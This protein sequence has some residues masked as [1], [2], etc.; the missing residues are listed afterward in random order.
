M[1]KPRAA[2]SVQMRN[3]ISPALKADRFALRSS[4]DF[5]P[6]NTAQEYAEVCKL[7]DLSYPHL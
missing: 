3:L 7:A 1:S 6:P 5:V 4:M 2:T